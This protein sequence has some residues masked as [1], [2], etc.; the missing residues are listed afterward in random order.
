M[1]RLLFVFFLVSLLVIPSVSALM[2]SPAKIAVDYAPGTEYEFHISVMDD[3][4]QDI[5]VEVSFDGQYADRVSLIDPSQER[6]A[7]KAGESATFN[8]KLDFP[9]IEQFGESR[10]VLVRFYQV[11]QSN[12]QVGA[13]VAILIPLDTVVPYPEKYVKIDLPDQGI[14]RQGETAN[15]HATLTSLGSSVIQ[16]TEGMFTVTNGKSSF[17]APIESF[18]LFIQQENRDVGAE[19]STAGMDSGFYNVTFTVTYDGESRTSEPTRLIVGTKDI[20]ITGISAEELQPRSNSFA[21]VLFNLWVEDLNPTLSLQLLTVSGDMVKDAPVGQYTVPAAQQKEI[22][23]T[24]DL[25]GVEEGTYTLRVISLLD[26]QEK[27]KDFKVSVLSAQTAQAPG[28]PIDPIL[29]VGLVVIALLIAVIVLCS[30][31]LWRR[32]NGTS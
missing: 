15:L 13:T 1:R 11:P 26:G 19:L 27:S 9:T 21:I 31:M 28:Q 7:L 3:G 12:A 4:P 20:E 14:V 32:R 24:L 2:V 30:V 22:F 8:F 18:P 16:N 5:V 17:D 29:I 6:V 25:S 10:F 23:T